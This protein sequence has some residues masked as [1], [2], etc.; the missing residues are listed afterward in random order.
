[1]QSEEFVFESVPIKD[2]TKKKDLT[3]VRGR[4][5]G[6]NGRTIEIIGELSDCDLTLYE[7]NVN[8]IGPADKIKD[9]ATAVKSIIHGA[10]TAK[11]Y[12]YLE[13][14]R[15]KPFEEDL[16]LKI[17]LDKNTNK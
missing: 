13:K 15:K 11:V 3:S 8:I 6:K 10:K 2:F 5:L 16:G 17:K 14:S 1:L 9:A 12:A 7:N 4:I